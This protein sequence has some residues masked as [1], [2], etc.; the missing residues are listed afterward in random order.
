MIQ[1]LKKRRIRKIKEE[2]AALNAEIPII[3]RILSGKHDTW[4][5]D[6]YRTAVRRRAK[7]QTRLGILTEFQ[8]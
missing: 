7:L 5:R 8:S 1:Y 2:I 6:N 4:D 3:E